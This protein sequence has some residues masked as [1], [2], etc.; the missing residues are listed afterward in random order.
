M[1][2]NRDDRPLQPLGWVRTKATRYILHEIADSLDRTT[3]KE[4]VAWLSRQGLS[5]DEIDKVYASFNENNYKAK[6]AWLTGKRFS[7]VESKWVYRIPGYYES[8]DDNSKWEPEMNFIADPPIRQQRSGGPKPEDEDY[9]ARKYVHDYLHSPGPQPEDRESLAGQ[10]GSNSIHAPGPR[11]EDQDYY[12]SGPGLHGIYAPG[13]GVYGPGPGLGPS[14]LPS[15]GKLH[16]ISY[17]PS[18]HVVT[19]TG[20]PSAVG[21]PIRYSQ[22]FGR[23]YNHHPGPSHD[24]SHGY[25]SNIYDPYKVGAATLGKSYAGDYTPD[26]SDEENSSG[27]NWS[28]STLAD[29]HAGPLQGRASGPSGQGRR[30]SGKTY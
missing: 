29:S 14:G 23:G 10:R 7:P 5:G 18:T 25:P 4:K 20:P 16:P 8:P 6:V 19:V 2:A 3:F 11:R 30:D 1:P 28:T 27:M 26:G 12:N 24:P 17:L 21:Y 15:N 22:S 9:H 13:Q